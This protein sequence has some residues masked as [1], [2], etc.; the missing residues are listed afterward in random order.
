LPPGLQLTENG[1]LQRG[2]EALADGRI[3]GRVLGKAPRVV[4]FVEPE[5]QHGRG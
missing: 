1:R 3:E 2:A 4:Q 5:V